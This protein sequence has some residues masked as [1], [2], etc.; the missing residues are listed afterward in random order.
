MG[1]RRRITII[2]S[3]A[4]VVVMLFLL[5]SIYQLGVT[6]QAG[7]YGPGQIQKWKVAV[8]SVKDIS[9]YR[10]SEI[11]RVPGN[12]KNMDQDNFV[13]VFTGYPLTSKREFEAAILQDGSVRILLPY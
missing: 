4:A 2:L 7:G 5:V 9:S 13:I 12:D 8:A 3:I 6:D 1:N 11:R 10:I